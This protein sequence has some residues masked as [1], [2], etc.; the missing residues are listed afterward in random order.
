MVN[1][2]TCHTILVFESHLRNRWDSKRFLSPTGG[3][4]KP[5]TF[6]SHNILIT[7][8]FIGQNQ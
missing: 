5:I 8:Q 1:I 3:T 2:K 6:V 4:Q 7:L